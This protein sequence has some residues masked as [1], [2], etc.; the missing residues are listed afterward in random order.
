MHRPTLFLTFSLALGA[1]AVAAQDRHPQRVLFVG[2]PDTPRGQAFVAF[3]GTKFAAVRAAKRFDDLGDLTAVDVV[4][5]DWPQQGAGSIS[6]WM[7]HPEQK[8]ARR[9][10]L[11]ERATWATPTVLLGSAGLN[12]ACVWDV[13]GS[14]G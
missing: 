10:P 6:E 2:E 14:S 4:V 12:L 1:G 7:E 9:A 11:G 5:L 3:L 8:A 13:R